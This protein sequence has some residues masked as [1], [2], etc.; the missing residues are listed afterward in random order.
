MAAQ[1]FQATQTRIEKL[2][3][4]VADYDRQVEE[5]EPFVPDRLRAKATAAR[6]NL[7]QAADDLIVDTKDLWERY[8]AR[9]QEHEALQAELI[10]FI[11]AYISCAD[12]LAL[13]HENAAAAARLLRSAGEVAANPQRLSVLAGRDWELRTLLQQFQEATRGRGL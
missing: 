6:E 12:Q 3:E 7:E 4:R 10:E 5:A 11:H 9:T 2:Q 1:E 8:T 13:A